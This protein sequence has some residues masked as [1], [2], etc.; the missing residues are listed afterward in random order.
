MRCTPIVQIFRITICVRNT[1][2]ANSP[3]PEI[4]LEIAPPIHSVNFLWGKLA[5][6]YFH[7]K[8]NCHTG[9]T[10]SHVIG[11]TT[12]EADRDLFSLTA[13]A[14]VSQLGSQQTDHRL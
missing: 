10:S 14:R 1:P 3:S 8:P 7:A 9:K 2:H 4:A 11:A 5:S 6:K 12:A 13:K